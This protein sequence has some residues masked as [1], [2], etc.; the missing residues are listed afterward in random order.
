MS[1]VAV[2]TI[3][4][5]S[6]LAVLMI[7]RIPI[8]FS[9]AISALVTATYLGIPYFNLFQKMSVSLLSF[10]FIAVPFFIMMAQVMTDGEITNKLMAFCN[11]LV[12]R[13]RGG[14][15]IV[16]ILVSMLFGGISGSSAADVSSIGAM[17]IPAM[18]KEGYDA[19]YSV[20]VTVTSSVEGVI[21]PPARICFFMRWL[22]QAVFLSALF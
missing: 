15:A 9:L 20:A 13:I 18:V 4:L 2:G 21:I 1:E 10:T 8:A 7:I 6:S 12:G 16:N 17:L 22:Q 19:D 5:F 14:T 11:I 3:L